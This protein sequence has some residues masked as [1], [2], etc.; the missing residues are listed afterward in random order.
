[1]IKILTLNFIAL[2]HVTAENDNTLQLIYRNLPFLLA[3]F[4]TSY[5]SLLFFV[6]LFF[7]YH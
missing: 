7:L 1:M 2:I 4:M 3:S 5:R 6:L